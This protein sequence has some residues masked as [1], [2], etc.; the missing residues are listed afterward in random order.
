MYRTGILFFVSIL[1]IHHYEYCS[2]TFCG[3]CSDDAVAVRQA[4]P[5]TTTGADV[6][7]PPQRQE[8]DSVIPV[9]RRSPTWGERYSSEE[10]SSADSQEGQERHV[11]VGRERQTPWAT[12]VST[13]VDEP[14]G[15]AASAS[16]E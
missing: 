12:P 5:R 6:P 3:C 8:N 1:F 10:G 7:Q 11:V 13:P 9:D 15:A 2:A 14:A 16:A 4:P